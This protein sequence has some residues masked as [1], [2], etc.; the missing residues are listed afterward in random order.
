VKRDPHPWIDAVRS[1]HDRL[2]ALVEPLSPDQVTGPSM[3]TDWSIAQV[4]SHLGSQGEI[5]GS[6]LDA[7]LEDRDLPGPDAFPPVWDAWNS[8]SATEQVAD[9][10]AV[11]EAF[12]RRIEA[13][14][15]TQ[16]EG[17]RFAMFGMDLDVVG[18]IQ[19]RLSE[20]ALHTWDVAAALD[21]RATVSADAVALVIDTLPE[22]A[23]R[24]GK[25]RDEAIR[26]RIVTSDPARDLSLVA[27]DEVL[28]TP[29]DG[30]ALDGVIRMPAEAWVRLVYGR[31][32]EEHSPPIERVAD[33][34]T[35]DQ[36]RAVFPGF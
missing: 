10:V 9:S 26:T 13:L 23:R 11:N 6:I 22:M 25:P 35:L 7:A 8:R 4:L 12:V 1:T 14:S 2:T 20:L 34:P 21:P 29:W 36:L 28:I 24:V 27:A 17:L 18:F 33:G 32:D 3:A 30:G 15:D 16:L 31:L 19:M 5:F